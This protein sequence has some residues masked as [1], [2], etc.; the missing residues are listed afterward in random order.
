MVN[1]TSSD[2]TTA[3]NNSAINNYM[4]TLCSPGSKNAVFRMKTR[5]Q[6]SPYPDA[7]N[8]EMTNSMIAKRNV[9]TASGNRVRPNLKPTNVVQANQNNITLGIVGRQKFIKPNNQRHTIGNP[10]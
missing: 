6:T 9:Q 5:Q 3:V 7:V 1:L 2:N 4:Q 8:Q 10:R